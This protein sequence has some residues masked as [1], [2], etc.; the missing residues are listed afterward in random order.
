MMR[1][2]FVLL[3][4]RAIAVADDPYD[5]PRIIIAL[6]K[7]AALGNHNAHHDL[8]TMYKNGWGGLPLDYKAA[9]EHYQF[10]AD[11]G[12]VPSA[13]LNLGVFF[14][15][16]LG[17]N[18][19]ETKALRYFELAAEQGDVTAQLNLGVS[20]LQNP[21]LDATIAVKWFEKAAA[22]GDAKAITQLG[23]CHAKGRVSLKIPKLLSLYL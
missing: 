8:G 15:Q 11:R 19:D 20:I 3:L 17:V 10:A 1:V 12:N 16:G 5:D 4:V 18:R 23:I 13:Q 22:T 2:P 7:Q 21:D 9:A 14:M 6:R